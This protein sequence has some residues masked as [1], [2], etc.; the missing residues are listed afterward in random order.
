MPEAVERIEC[1]MIRR[2]L[3]AFAGNR[4]QAAEHLGM[5]RQLLYQKLERYGLVSP[6]GTDNV[7]EADSGAASK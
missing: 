7:L 5:R 4:A 6:N 1:E 2:A 3:L